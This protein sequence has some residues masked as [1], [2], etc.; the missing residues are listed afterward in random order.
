MTQTAVDT[1]APIGLPGQLATE[2][3]EF[4]ALI[5]SGCNEEAVANL[6]FGIAVK[7]GS[8]K[9]LVKLPTL[10]ADVID[11]ILVHTDELDF[12]SQT[13][14][15]TVNTFAQTAIQP[16]VTAGLLKRGTIYVVP[17]ATG[18]AASQVHMRIVASGGNTQLGSFT[19][20]AEAAKTVNWTP[21]ARWLEPPVRWC[22]DAALG[23]PDDD[24][25]RNRG[26]TPTQS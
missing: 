24:R 2:W 14:D 3:D 20:T 21:F 18:V 15:A 4:N 25:A 1:V 12:P 7:R 16:K 6:P 5:D 22:S 17:E 23:R 10:L 26:L 11:G 13:I 19:P 9:G 8:A